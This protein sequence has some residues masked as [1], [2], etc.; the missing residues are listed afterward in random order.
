[1]RLKTLFAVTGIALVITGTAML[2]PL[3]A[4][5]LL[6]ESHD[7]AAFIKAAV[8]TVVVGFTILKTSRFDSGMSNKEGIIIGALCWLII[9]MFGCLPYLFSGTF[10]S[11]TDAYFEAVSGFTTTGA[12]VMA[13]I[14][15]ASRSILLWRSFTQWLGGM[16]ILLVLIAL[17]PGTSH[18]GTKLLRAETPGPLTFKIVPRFSQYA[19]AI[20]KVYI[21]L[22]VLEVG[23]LC[24]AGLTFY[25]SLNHTFTSI[26]TGGFS[27]RNEGLAAFNNM[28]VEYIVIFFMII[29]GGNYVLYYI[30]LKRKSLLMLFAD[31][32]Y[33]AYL[34]VIAVSFM[35]VVM[36][37]VLSQFGNIYDAIRYGFFQVV[38][39]K[40][41]AGH[42]TYDYDQWNNTIKMLLFVL[43]FF[44]GCQYSTTGGIK[45]V[46]MLIGAKFI[47]REVHK[48]L[49]PSAV[50]SININ[51][52]HIAEPVILSVIGFFLLYFIFFFITSL[53]L[54]GYGFD[55]VSSIT[56]SAAIL[57]NV[58]PAMGIF[59]PTYNY[60]QLPA[61]IKIWLSL[62]M[63]MGRLEIYPILILVKVL[64]TPT[65][66]HQLFISRQP[67][68]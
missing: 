55:Q 2:L 10:T 65:E 61:V 18:G 28:W 3:V 5:L 51:S 64:L 11:F 17:F 15:A 24:L 60:A 59:G 22:T 62:T 12:T 9:P 35:L 38:S 21:G 6:R 36:S 68:Q 66:R 23:L 56:A 39:L 43:M 30:A 31:E 27:T 16:G 13:D 4:A 44:G 42:V 20:W 19:Q 7:A 50:S 46:R 34:A 32:E 37:L 58:G 47:R 40:T 29:G 41:G 14:E 8:I 63:I 26:A 45:M 48:Q 53:V 49:H 57:G 52:R 67:P 1:M 54:A 25:E 33:R